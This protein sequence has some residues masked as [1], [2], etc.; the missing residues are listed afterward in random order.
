[1][2]AAVRIIKP[3]GRW[4]VQSDHEEYFAQMHGLLSAHSELVLIRWEEGGADPGPEWKG[5]NYEIK[6]TREE[7]ESSGRG[8][9][10][11]MQRQ[12]NPTE[13]SC[14]AARFHL[15]LRHF[16][17]TDHTLLRRSRFLHETHVESACQN[18]QRGHS[19]RGHSEPSTFFGRRFEVIEV[20]FRDPTNASSVGGRDSL[21]NHQPRERLS[22]ALSRR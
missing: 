4:L 22:T 13:G 9:N 8:F 5:T 10:G 2:D 18:H 12:W 3:G 16:Y 17:R 6:Y 11:G 1:M 15:P 19:G 14:G 21:S 20:E 7:V